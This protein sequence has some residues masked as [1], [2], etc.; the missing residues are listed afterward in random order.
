LLESE[1]ET[2]I[3]S[4]FQFLVSSCK[5]GGSWNKAE[6]RTHLIGGPVGAS[7]V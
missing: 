2:G 1:R 7:V 4:S 6:I 3:V 5:S